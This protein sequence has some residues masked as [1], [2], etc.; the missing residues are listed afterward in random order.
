V[1]NHEEYDHSEDVYNV[2]LDN[3]EPIRLNESQV[4]GRIDDLDP[5]KVDVVTIDGE[6]HATRVQPQDGGLA[7]VWADLPRFLRGVVVLLAVAIVHFAVTPLP[8]VP[9]P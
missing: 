4:V 7:V 9:Y 2:E 6:T 3:G 5:I 1:T 8:G